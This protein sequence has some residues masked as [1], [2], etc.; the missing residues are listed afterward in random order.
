[1]ITGIIQLSVLPHCQHVTL[2]E[3]SVIKLARKRAV[4]LYSLQH[5]GSP[6]IALRTVDRYQLQSGPIGQLI[7]VI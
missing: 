3:K 6:H 1:M 5:N 4:W 7:T 2:S